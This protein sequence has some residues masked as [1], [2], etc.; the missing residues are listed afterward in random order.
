[1]SSKEKAV[2]R[3]G[4][5][6]TRSYCRTKMQKESILDKIR[7][8]GFRLTNQREILIDIILENECSSCKEIY[9]KATKVDEQIGI[10]TV[11]R[12]INILEEIGAINRKNLYK[13]VYF[14]NCSMEDAC[15]V[16]LEDN[17]T[18]HLSAKKWNEVVIAGLNAK[19]YLSNKGIR[20][21]AVRGC[22]GQECKLS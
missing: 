5:Y 13:V 17:T 14:D 22:E 11:Y 19:G 10:A 2:N 3:K 8:K 4:I 21:I 18:V 12:I 7:E 16:T 15:T 6:D 9:Y 1:M 20:S